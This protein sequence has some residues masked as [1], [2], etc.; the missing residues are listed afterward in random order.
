MKCLKRQDQ[1]ELN[2]PVSINYIVLPAA[3][4][5]K[6][7]LRVFSLTHTHTLSLVN[8]RTKNAWI[9]GKAR[10]EKRVEKKRNSLLQMQTN[11]K[12]VNPRQLMKQRKSACFRGLPHL[13]SVRPRVGALCVCLCE[14]TIFHLSP[15]FINAFVFL[16][17]FRGDW[18]LSPCVYG[19]V[20]AESS[21][22]P[23]TKSDVCGWSGLQDPACACRDQRVDGLRR[24]RRRRSRYRWNGT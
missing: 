24:E 20:L 2:F 7:C 19:T 1:P 21:T 22:P 9:W 4:P 12:K 14:P 16:F 11:G 6:K 23:I 10:E 8:N 3:V 5:S 13:A 15:C 17:L 18:D